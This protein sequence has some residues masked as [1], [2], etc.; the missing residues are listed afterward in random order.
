MG[1]VGVVTLFLVGNE[2]GFPV[3]S[4][5]GFFVSKVVGLG[6]G[7]HLVADFEHGVQPE[8]PPFFP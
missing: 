3:G 7:T 4:C 6:V 8:T 5:V 2:V 1:G